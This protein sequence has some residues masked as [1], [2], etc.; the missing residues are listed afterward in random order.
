MLLLIAA[1]KKYSVLTSLAK[2]RARVKISSN[3]RE[4]ARAG[5]GKLVYF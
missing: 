4:G 2:H 3:P 1:I 5:E